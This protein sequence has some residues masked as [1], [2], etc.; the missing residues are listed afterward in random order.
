MPWNWL[1]VAVGLYGIFTFIYTFFGGGFCG[2]EGFY[3]L[4]ARSVMEGMKPYR[5]FGI[6][7]MPLLPYWYGAWF[8]LV[9]TSVE[10]GR[11][12]SAGM[13]AGS[14]A[15]I[16]LACYRRGGRIAAIVGG[17]LIGSNLHFI[18]DTFCVKTQALTIFLTSCTIFVLSK[19][20]VRRPVLQAGLAMLF[21]TLALVARLSILPMLLLVWLYMGWKLR[22][23]LGTFLVLW[24]VNVLVLV[25][26]YAYFGSNGNMVYW[27][28]QFH[29]E[30][31]NFAPWSFQRWLM[32]IH[33]WLGNELPIIMLF[34]CATWAFVA[35]LVREKQ[36]IKDDSFLFAA[37]LLLCYWGATALHWI[38]AQSYA[39]HQTS[40]IAF[41][42]VFGAVGL[43]PLFEKLCKEDKGLWSFA[44]AAL[45]VLPLQLGEI[46]TTLW[47]DSSGNQAMDAIHEA[48]TLLS[49]HAKKGDSILSFSSELAVNG[50]Y[51]VP[52]GYEF[53]E[54]GYF[55]GM[56][57]ERCAKLHTLN[58][59]KLSEDISAAKSQIICFDER[60]FGLMA[61]QNQ[62]IAN[63]LQKR[64]AQGYNQVGI[65]KNYGQFKLNLYIFARK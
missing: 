11:V 20:N 25:G 18:A 50:G 32:T 7:Q 44:F 35:K 28:V 40:I 6:S 27:V 1:L 46:G 62:E 23:S 34:F 31:N 63:Q 8:S 16:C 24:A 5:D 4:A 51:R 3:T 38:N 12:L 33:S 26:V 47:I 61:G 14:V 65:V 13:A 59:K 21:I 2:D 17:L 22:H 56:S 10:A 39:T 60:L 53:N 30:Y 19:T 36:S 58:Y 42:T 49:K 64:I 43:A 54:F 48:E 37:F 57:D 9:G 55:P 52:G 29:N 45:L 15:L 41:A